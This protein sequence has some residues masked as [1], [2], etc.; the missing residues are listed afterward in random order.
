[1]KYIDN[2]INANIVKLEDENNN[3]MSKD[4]EGA[5]EEIDSKIKN[6]EVNGYDDT[7][8]RQDIN[9]IK[10]EVGAAILTTTNKTIKGA[11]NEINSQINNIKNQG[12]INILFLGAKNDGSEDIGN[13]I[14]QYT[15]RF[16]IYIPE[17]IYK[18]STPIVL[19]NSLYGSGYIREFDLGNKNQTVLKS[20]LSNGALIT[21]AED[22]NNLN[23]KDLALYLNGEENGIDIKLT[24]SARLAFSNIGIYNLSGIGINS[25]P[26]IV[27][28]RLVFIS[29][30]TIFGKAFA[31]STGIVMNVYSPDSRLSNIEI[32]GTK[33]GMNIH[34]ITYGDNIH[35]WTG[36]MAGH[37]E[38]D[39]WAETRGL[40]SSYPGHIFFNNLYLDSCFI[41]F[42]LLDKGVI[43]V[44]NFIYWEDES[45]GG[46]SR[47]D[48]S[49]MY[50][51]SPE[52]KTQLIITNG[53]LNTGARMLNV[54]SFDHKIK[55]TDVMFNIRRELNNSNR[56]FY[57][58]TQHK[59]SYLRYLSN[60]TSENTYIPIACINLSN[61]NEHGLGA[62][63]ANVSMSGGQD[64]T[65][66]VNITWDTSIVVKLTKNN[67]KTHEF[68]YK[69]DGQLL[70][71]YAFLAPNS[72][73]GFIVTSEYSNGFKL[74]DIDSIT[75]D[76]GDVY[77]FPNSQNSTD[78]LTQIVLS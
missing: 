12:P 61:D 66:Y 58:F 59:I 57:P 18:V 62:Y 65:L 25:I 4:V 75:N 20:E 17:G 70:Y 15:D 48:G 73:Q 16:S 74:L 32:M 60:N 2:R 63:K 43:N 9:N 28:S 24:R 31:D 69:I 10:T 35:I 22:A 11:V 40:Q 30:I 53:I 5:L 45:M 34:T 44:T 26:K 19:K 77:Y 64:F 29:D 52:S 49:F 37:D 41:P 42:V 67:D 51:V 3:Y 33:Y 78:G 71:V 39:W 55:L 56:H 14:N 76:P 47:S 36:C 1:M 72:T 7:Q 50:T 46:C 6:I 38:N 27:I 8:I 68:Y 23:I 13:I 54:S 21:V